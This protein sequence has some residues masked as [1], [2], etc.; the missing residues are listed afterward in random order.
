M[1]GQPLDLSHIMGFSYW[2]MSGRIGALNTA[3][4]VW[5]EPELLPSPPMIPTVGRLAILIELCVD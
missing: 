4:R 1:P 2:T 3:G 5:V